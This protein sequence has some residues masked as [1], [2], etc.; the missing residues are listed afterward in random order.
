MDIN[1]TIKI[2]QMEKLLDV[3]NQSLGKCFASVD[4]TSTESQTTEQLI[5][6]T[7][8]VADGITSVLTS[9]KAEA[10]A[11]LEAIPEPQVQTSQTVYTMDE[12]AAAATPLMDKG[13]QAELMSLIQS[14]GVDSLVALPT[15]CYGDFA[16]ALRGLGAKI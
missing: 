9:P 3:F 16:I 6:A 7:K 5:E 13:L 4:L 1:I 11:I 2:E 10:K 12:L 8:E 14:F 15:T